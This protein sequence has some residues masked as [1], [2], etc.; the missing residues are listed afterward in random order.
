MELICYARDGAVL[1][2]RPASSRRDWMDA[3]PGQHAYRCLPLTHANQH[4]WEVHC[5]Q[6]FTARWNGGPLQSD[7]RFT[8]FGAGASTTVL[9]AFGSGIITFQIP[10]LFKTPPGINLWVMGPPN[11]IKDGVQPLSGIVEADWLEEHS[12]TMNWKITRP[13]VEVVFQKG[14]PFCFISPI[15]R[16]LAESLQPRM[17]RLKDAPSV[18]AAHQQGT[19]RRQAFQR[20]HDIQQDGAVMRPGEQ[21]GQAWQRRYYRGLDA[22]GDAVT[23]HQTRLHLRPFTGGIEE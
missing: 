9:S 11:R 14:E 16:G 17:L 21:Q 15:P 5:Q 3:T 8:M 1:D 6:T 18:A 23:K 7:L 4:G 13:G 19:Q 20:Q 10:C 2:I 12:F 22:N